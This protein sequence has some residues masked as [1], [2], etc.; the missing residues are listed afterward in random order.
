[1]SAVPRRLRLLLALLGAV[2]VAVMVFV[3]AGLKETTNTVVTYRTSDQVAMVGLGL[4]L[5]AGI[6]F[7]G[8]SRVDADADGVRVRN[9]VVRHELPWQAVRAV[10]FERKSPWASLLLE[11]DD[12]IS[13]L[14]VQAVDKEHAVR[15]VESLRALHA[16]ARAK[17][18]VPP[19]L[20][21]DD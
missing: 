8:R 17:D 12:E 14:A 2:V 1:M 10:R 21:Y 18:P 3:A 4:V 9:V 11:N 7:L 20:L 15:A 16:A 6:L 13:L 19:P 5:A